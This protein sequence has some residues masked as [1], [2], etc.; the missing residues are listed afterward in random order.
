M[1]LSALQLRLVLQHLRIELLCVNPRQHLPLLDVI[2]VLD[3]DLVHD[4]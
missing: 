1:E 2:V 3:Q 4:A